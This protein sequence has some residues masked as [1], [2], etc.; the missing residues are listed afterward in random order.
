MKFLLFIKKPLVLC[1]NV[2]DVII[3]KNNNSLKTYRCLSIFKRHFETV[4]AIFPLTL[5]EFVPQNKR[6]QFC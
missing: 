6:K 3:Q 4:E 1:Q 2:F 5:T